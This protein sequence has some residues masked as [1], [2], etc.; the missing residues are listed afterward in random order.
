MHLTSLESI[1]RYFKKFGRLLELRLFETKQS[2]LEPQKHF[3]FVLYE[4]PASIEL[5]LEGGDSH[6]IN[7]CQVKCSRIKLD[8]ERIA[9]N[10]YKLISGIETKAS[11]QTKKLTKASLKKLHT[12]QLLRNR[13]PKL[14]SLSFEQP[15]SETIREIPLDILS[16]PDTEVHPSQILMDELDQVLRKEKV[17]RSSSSPPRIS[18]AHAK[19]FIHK[20]AEE[21]NTV[22][23]TKSRV[24]EIN[25]YL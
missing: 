25:L 12:D 8:K 7:R 13:Q 22:F 20:Q 3:G 11:L 5:V 1:E 15:F 10:S 4:D 19:R 9:E 17:F 16:C 6:L 21:T 18:K 14:K 24:E 23:P 2:I